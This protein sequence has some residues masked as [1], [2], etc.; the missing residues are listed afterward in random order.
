MKYTIYH[1]TEKAV[2]WSNSENTYR[3]VPRLNDYKDLGGLFFTA[4]ITATELLRKEGKTSYTITY[5]SV[6]NEFLITLS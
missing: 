3:L 1:E 2:I 5:V 4:Y 6:N